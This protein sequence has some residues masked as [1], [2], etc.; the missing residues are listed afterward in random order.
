MAAAG[1]SSSIQSLFGAVWT[2]LTEEPVKDV[3]SFWTEESKI[4]RFGNQG[5]PILD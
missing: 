4:A 2:P 1:V 5:T 3:V